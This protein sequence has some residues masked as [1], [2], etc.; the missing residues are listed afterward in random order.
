MSHVK[1]LE[2]D[3]S[4]YLAHVGNTT[5]ISS[6]EIL[7]HSMLEVVATRSLC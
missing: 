6:L 1:A 7:K 5:S 4:F 3:L 2:S